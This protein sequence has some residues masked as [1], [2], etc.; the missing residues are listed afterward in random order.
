MP[1][2]AAHTVAL[3]YAGGG[4]PRHCATPGLAGIT[5]PPPPFTRRLARRPPLV[6]P[7]AVAGPL[8]ELPSAVGSAPGSVRV[9][10][11]SCVSGRAPRARARA[12]AAPCP[13]PASR[14]AQMGAPRRGPLAC[15]RPPPLPLHAPRGA[16]RANVKDVGPRTRPDPPRRTQT[17]VASQHLVLESVGRCASALNWIGW[18]VFVEMRGI[19]GR[20]LDRYH[21]SRRHLRL[22]AMWGSAS[23]VEE[24]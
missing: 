12:P 11:R 15:A 17:Q 18:V 1:P 20:I 16:T 7:G 23:C 6:P 3:T 9:C 22:G 10:V 21:A 4:A 13:L 14:V 24:H 5:G 19:M 2:H 8:G